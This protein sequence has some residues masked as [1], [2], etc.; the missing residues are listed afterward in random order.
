VSTQDD[1]IVEALRSALKETDRLREENRRLSRQRTA[2]IAIVAMGCRFPGAVTTPEELWR[3]LDEGRDVIGPFPDDRGWDLDTLFS[4][5]P[6]QPGTCNAREGGFLNGA[7]EFDAAFFGISPREALAMDP[8]QRL[9]LELAW[10]TV[11]RAGI[12]PR[13]LAGTSTGVYLGAIAARYGPAARHAP[14]ELQGLALVGTTTSVVSGRVAYALGLEGPAV[15]VDTACSSSLL[16]V[17]QAVGALRAGECS[18]ALAGGVTVMA[19]PDGFTE[20]GRQRGLAPDG[21]CKAF[22]AA[23]DGAGFSEGAGLVLLERLDDARRHGHP[24]LA[25]IRGGAANSDGASNGL[26]APNGPSQRRVIRSALQAAGLEPAQVD[27]VE[28]HGTGT[29]LGD[30]I[31]AQA[32]LEVYGRDRPPERPLRLGSL[33]SNIGHAQAAAGVGGLIKMVLALQHQR[34]PATLHVDAPTPHVDWSPAAVELLTEAMPWPAGERP[35]RA[36]ISSFGISGTNVHLLIEE[37]PHDDIA[38][39]GPD[40]RPAVRPAQARDAEEAALPWMLSAAD[41]QALRESAQRL[42]EHL[43]SETVPG[44]Q[45]GVADVGWSLATTRAHLEQRA[46]VV[47]RGRKELLHQL[48]AVIGEASGS[49][50]VR[51]RARGHREIAFVFPG[52]GALGDGRMVEDGVVGVAHVGRLLPHPLRDPAHPRGPVVGDVVALRHVA[53]RLRALARDVRAERRSVQQ[54]R[55]HRAPVTMLFPLVFLILPAFVLAA[56]VPAVLV[57]TDGL[58]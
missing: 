17:H 16:A 31:E 25:V 49:G 35:R 5:D 15:T 24:V 51:G 9:V 6:E 33:K 4:D 29:T 42:W 41:P 57:A 26:T 46:V 36:G 37:A 44:P 12:A 11:E 43:Q 38:A 56:V 50:V 34:L 2:P 3:V 53:E 45:A 7:G 23:A 32:L 19:T 27:A 18:L 30:P 52:Q 39:D 55:A 20:I 47:A 54:E 13:S 1:R 22:A 21:R 58:M 40:A 48:L 8:Q 10:E 14:P 28:A